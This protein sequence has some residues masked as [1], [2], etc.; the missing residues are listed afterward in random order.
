MSK[1][2]TKKSESAEQLQ[3]SI[4]SP[5]NS[6]AQNNRCYYSKSLI[7]NHSTK[8]ILELE[9]EKDEQKLSFKLK[10]TL[11]KEGYVPFDYRGQFDL[12]DLSEKE[13]SVN[14][15]HDMIEI[16][17]IFVSL[18]SSKKIR[19]SFSE[20]KETLSLKFNI[21]VWCVDRSFT[22][23]LK[24]YIAPDVRKKREDLVKLF[25][26]T[27]RL[28]KEYKAGHRKHKEEQRKSINSHKTAAKESDYDFNYLVRYDNRFLVGDPKP[29]YIRLKNTGR[30][31]WTPQDNIKLA[32]A[33]GVLCNDYV[34]QQTIEPGEETVCDIDVKD[35]A[36]LLSGKKTIKLNFVVDNKT[37]KDI[38]EVNFYAYSDKESL[39]RI[40]SIRK[41][42]P[43]GTKNMT[44]EELNT[45]AVRH[46]N[47]N[48]L[49]D[50]IMPK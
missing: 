14:G 9:L 2:E 16:F 45:R 48:S 5:D 23:D 27:K 39:E 10:E 38:F 7:I 47:N 41:M 32:S 43:E 33:G 31:P 4:T 20:D 15:F 50:S 12:I 36:F 44:D 49:I 24:R 35:S 26:I 28:R 11:P 1:I 18:I 29:I 13:Y 46:S 40:E 22:L 34:F 37:I 3:G 19:L 6:T 25:K 42:D 8:F 17:K 21:T 30:K